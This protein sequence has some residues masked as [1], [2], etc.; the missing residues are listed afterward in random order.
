MAVSSTGVSSGAAN[1]NADAFQ[2]Q[3]DVIE[4]KSMQNTLD[5]SERDIKDAYVSGY[6][7]SITTM[8]SSQAS[9]KINF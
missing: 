7:N 5:K 6:Q 3:M 2:A 8:I 9:D 4:A 1:Q